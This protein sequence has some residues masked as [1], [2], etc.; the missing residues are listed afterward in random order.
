MRL[1]CVI[2]RTVVERGFIPLCRGAVGV[3][4]SLS[5]LGNFVL[6]GGSSTGDDFVE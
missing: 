2:Y 1:F 4:Y 6:S 5:R 3:F